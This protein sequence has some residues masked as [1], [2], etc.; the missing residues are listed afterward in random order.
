MTRAP[1]RG[2]LHIET[3]VPY[4]VNRA[5]AAMIAYSAEAFKQHDLTVPQWRI[6]FALSDGDGCRFGELARLTSIEP[7]TL[8]RLL[9]GMVTD[10]LV[11][12]S[13]TETDGRGS[14]IA[15]TAAGRSCFEGT[16]D[17]ARDVQELYTDGLSEQ[18]LHTLRRA[19]TTIYENVRTAAAAR[20]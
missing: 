20:G 14:H 5:A 3:Y 7:P 10:G 13:R 18:D 6:L 15:L 17:F 9:N 11:S 2:G 4:L 1:R 19:L 12:R 16:L 8:S